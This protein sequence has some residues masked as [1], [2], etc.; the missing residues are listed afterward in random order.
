MS[1]KKSGKKEKDT[2]HLQGTVK[3]KHTHVES[4]VLGP[5]ETTTHVT[6][7]FAQCQAIKHDGGR[8]SNRVDDGVRY[9]GVHSA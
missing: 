3:D 7:D 9:C 5:H 1:S 4:K 6:T 8:C 2:H